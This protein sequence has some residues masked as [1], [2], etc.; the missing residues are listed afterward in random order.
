[1]TAASLGTLNDVIAE[2]RGPALL[3]D[4][5]RRRLADALDTLADL[6]PEA[7]PA[8][9]GAV[10]WIGEAQLGALRAGWSATCYGEQATEYAGSRSIPAKLVPLYAAPAPPP[11][12]AVRALVGK[13]RA[14]AM[15]H[16]VKWRNKE[17][18]EW[19]REAHLAR[20]S[21]LNGCANKLEA[22]LSA[23]PAEEDD[24]GELGVGIQPNP[25]ARYWQERAAFWRET[26]KALGYVPPGDAAA[27]TPEVGRRHDPRVEDAARA[28]YDAMPYDEPGVKP[29]WVPHGNS[30]K[31]DEARARAREQL[32]AK[33]PRHD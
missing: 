25:K 4:S 23:A 19:L 17:N 16:A 26:A 10:A 7:A 3:F 9:G 22:A 20:A 2:L 6:T 13:W 11:A 33:E 21:E 24:P 32:A 8:A 28:I 1:M 5:D 15:E 31:Q 30:I 12:D 18:A 27:P 29:A 14:E